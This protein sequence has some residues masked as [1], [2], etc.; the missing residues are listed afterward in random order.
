MKDVQVIQSQRSY[1]TKP[2]KFVDEVLLEKLTKLHLS[3]KVIS[4]ALQISVDTLHRRYADKM[5]AWKAESKV[6]I[7]EVLLDEAINFRTPW[8]LKLYAQRFLGYNEQTI[9]AEIKH[10]EEESKSIPIKMTKA[11]KL[12]MLDQL[13]VIYLAEDDE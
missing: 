5:S 12:E 6:K 3:D 7:A 13:R 4:D 2:E 10:P 9:A 11:E 8:A 1:K